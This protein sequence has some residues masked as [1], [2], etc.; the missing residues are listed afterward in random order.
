MQLILFIQLHFFLNFK[1]RTVAGGWESVAWS[2]KHTV[3]FK[4]MASIIPSS[5]LRIPRFTSSNLF[6]SGRSPLTPK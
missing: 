5:L 3:Y 2:F 6:L 1:Y 4:F